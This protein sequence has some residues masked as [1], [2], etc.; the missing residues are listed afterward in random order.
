MPFIIGV[1]YDRTGN[2][3]I[4]LLMFLAFVLLMILFA[5]LLNRKP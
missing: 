5:Y 2:H 1:V 4:T 3:D